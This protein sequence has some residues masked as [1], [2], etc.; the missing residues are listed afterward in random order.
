MSE[1]RAPIFVFGV[2]RSGTTLTYSL[3]LASGC[4]PTY[5]AES[6]ILECA[7]RYGSLRSPRN[8]RAFLED[9]FHSRQFTRSGLSRDV[10]TELAARRSASWTDFL[11]GFMTTI[12]HDQGKTRWAEKSPNNGYFIDPIAEH[13]PEARFIHVI[14]DGRS[15][16]ASQRKLGWGEKYS[17][18]HRR[19]LLWI[20]SVWELQVRAGRKAARLGEDRYLEI[21]YEDLILNS[22]ETVARIGEFAG[23]EL[24]LDTVNRSQVGALGVSNTAFTLEQGGISEGAV[25]RWR[26]TLHDDE[27]ALLDWHLGDLLR[28]LGYS[29]IG[30]TYQPSWRDRVTASTSKLAL[31][32]KRILNLHTPLG[33]L[34]RRPLEIGLS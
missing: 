17:R 31:D 26:T 5:A 30:E 19:Q 8:R 29:G 20:G 33:R 32:S 18:D 21:R 2:A 15:V 13:Y 22:A 23:L 9:F 16:T 1:I 34:A 12:A 10:V 4:L 3:L 27:I 14:R 28:E 6:R 24:D 11:D 7:S 25:D